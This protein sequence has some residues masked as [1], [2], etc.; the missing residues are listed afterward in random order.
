MKSLIGYLV[1]YLLTPFVFFSHVISFGIFCS[2]AKELYD[3]GQL[4]RTVVKQEIVQ[5]MLWLLL[6]AESLAISL[7][8]LFCLRLC[9]STA[10]TFVAVYQSTTV[11][12]GQ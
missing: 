3:V 10:D 1:G 8:Q 2:L 4:V 9:D 7:L 11:T 5:L 6:P 12:T